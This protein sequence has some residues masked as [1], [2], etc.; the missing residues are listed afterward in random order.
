MAGWWLGRLTDHRKRRRRQSR[1]GGRTTDCL[2]MDKPGSSSQSKNM[3]RSLTHGY[4]EARFRGDGES[5]DR[6]NHPIDQ[7]V[8]TRISLQ[9]LQKMPHHAFKLVG[10]PS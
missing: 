2:K 8:P 10:M 4:F 5:C 7:W 3:G 9:I 6:S 1:V